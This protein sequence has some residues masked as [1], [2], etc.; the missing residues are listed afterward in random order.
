MSEA[1]KHDGGKPRLD[2]IPWPAIW[3][4]AK[5]LGFGAQKYSSW[6]WIGGISYSRL[7]AGVQRHLTAWI[8]GEDNDPESGLSHLAHAACGILFLLTFKVCGRVELD[9]RH[10]YI[11]DMY[12]K[13]ESEEWQQI[14][15][16]EL[17]KE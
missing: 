17:S 8:S 11:N 10:Q 7:F 12:S 14:S 1:K 3:A 9:D 2:L 4:I 5:V 13:Y 16:Q 6:N 15:G